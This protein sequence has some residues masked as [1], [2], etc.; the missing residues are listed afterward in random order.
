MSCK[1]GKVHFIVC[2]KG[3]TLDFYTT[4]TSVGK[5][6]GH[7]KEKKKTHILSGVFSINIMMS[8][9]VDP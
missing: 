2:V 1:F 8:A 7:Y 6:K 3:E 4:G 5:L 9:I